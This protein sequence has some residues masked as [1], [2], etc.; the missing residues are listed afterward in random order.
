MNEKLGE[1]WFSIQIVVFELVII[2]G[3]GVIVLWTQLFGRRK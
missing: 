3:F 1:I 2:A